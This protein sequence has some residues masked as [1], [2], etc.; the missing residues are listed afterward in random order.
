MQ[1]A[2]NESDFVIKSDHYWKAFS[3]KLFWQLILFFR[4][5]RLNS[6]AKE[7]IEMST[8]LNKTWTW[9]MFAHKNILAFYSKF[10]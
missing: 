2:V 3:D 7:L 1:N 4:N 9:L 8:E 6:G 10:N 5:V